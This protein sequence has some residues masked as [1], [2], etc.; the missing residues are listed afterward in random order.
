MR[1]RAVIAMTMILSLILVG[2]GGVKPAPART[3]ATSP[4]EVYPPKPAPSALK[5][6]SQPPAMQIDVNREYSAV[7]KTSLGD[8]EI[9]L[10]AKDAP[11]TVNNFVFL[12]NEGFYEGV[13][14]HRIMKGF[15]V[16]T[17]D[18]L[19][20]GGGGPGYRFNDELPVKRSYDP[21]IVAMANAGP[22]T[23]GSQ[24]FICNGPS[25]R[26]LDSMP[27]Y[28]QFGQVRSGMDV[29]EKLSNVEVGVSASGERSVPKVAPVIQSVVIK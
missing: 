8:I 29:L 19:G 27:N 18:P 5:Q 3:P 11:N 21:G 22:N 13:K 7:I 12:A 4:T 16:Q 24:F 10:F 25:C 28:T 6:W 9:E 1:T 2:C 23:N 14:F 26:N 17:G 20:T 15:M